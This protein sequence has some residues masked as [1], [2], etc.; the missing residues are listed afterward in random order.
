MSEAEIIHIVAAWTKTII[1]LFLLLK[2][3]FYFKFVTSYICW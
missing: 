1:Y 2:Y 3:V